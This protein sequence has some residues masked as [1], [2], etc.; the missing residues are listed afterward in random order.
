MS[1]YI[2]I[3]IPKDLA[4]EMDRLV[5]TRGFKSRGEIAKEAIRRFLDERQ[6]LSQS[7]M[8]AS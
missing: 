2:P 3:K 5:G 1:D 4:D 7:Q 8:E 6:T